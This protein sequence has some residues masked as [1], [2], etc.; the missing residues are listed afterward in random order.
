MNISV[1]QL[2]ADEMDVRLAEWLHLPV[3]SRVQRWCGR[4]ETGSDM[5]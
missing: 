3:T 5:L 1:Q 4:R 2:E